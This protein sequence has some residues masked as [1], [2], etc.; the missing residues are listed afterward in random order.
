MTRP[1]A[2]IGEDDLQLHVD[3][4]LPDDRRAVVEAYLAGEPEVRVRVERERRQRQALAEALRWKAEEP[5][6]ARLRLVHLGAERH[7]RAAGRLRVAAA[8]AGLFLLGCGS[9]WLLARGWP[10]APAAVPVAA[11]SGEAVAAYRTYVVEVA[12]PVEVGS[13]NEQH[14]MAWLSKRLGRRLAAPD[15][16]AFGYTLMGGRLL[17]A[18]TGAAAQ[19]MYQTPMGARLTLYIQGADG[20]ETA[21]QFFEAG[22]A[23]T[24]AWRDAG[25]GFAVT[26]P[27]PRAALTP[28][29]E[30]VYRRLD[31]GAR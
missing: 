11:V 5:I 25:Y 12:H 9:G 7:R 8:A 17:P 6:P 16:S 30:A 18:G 3:G 19:L 14:L 10:A 2:P 31:A 20:G 15:L 21:F 13:D 29:A 22:G 1:N 28:I 24:L 4:R 27:L 26:A 23:A